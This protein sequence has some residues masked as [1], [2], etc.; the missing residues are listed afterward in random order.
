MHSVTNEVDRN[1]K[2]KKEDNL[3][4]SPFFFPFSSSLIIKLIYMLG[5]LLVPSNMVTSSLCPN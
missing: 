5:I 2:A 3:I 4:L 1:K